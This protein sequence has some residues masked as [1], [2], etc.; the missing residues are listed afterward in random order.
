ML[1]KWK[2]RDLLIYHLPLLP[3][4]QTGLASRFSLTT[5]LPDLAGFIWPQI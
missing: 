2:G 3:H 4:D 5:F 1:S